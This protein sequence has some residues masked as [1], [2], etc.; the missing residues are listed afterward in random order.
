MRID[1]G[2]PD[3]DAERS[4]L[5]GVDRRDLISGLTPCL[6]QQELIALQQQ[7]KEVHVAP[8]LL[9]YVQAIIAYTRQSPD[10]LNGMSP[11]AALALLHAAR[12]WAMMDARNKVLPEDV[13]AVLPSV[14]SHRLH[15]TREPSNANSGDHIE[16]L[17]RSI[18]IP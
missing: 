8:A 15:L 6:S 5:Q 3:S 7:V 16:Q 18:A 4:L 2:Y 14:V 10:Y 17:I 13:Q 11:R 1:L 12:A 9:D